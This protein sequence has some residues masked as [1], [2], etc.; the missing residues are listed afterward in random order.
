MKLSRERYE[1]SCPDEVEGVSKF[2]AGNERIEALECL[3]VILV[4]FVSERGEQVGVR[5]ELCVGN[6]D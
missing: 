2:K 5:L 4:D 1:N 6:G 3:G